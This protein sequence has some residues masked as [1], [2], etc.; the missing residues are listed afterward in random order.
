MRRPR[1]ILYVDGFNLYRRCLSSHPALK[2]LDLWTLGGL[3]M[4][5][6]DLIHVHYFTAR[7]RPGI[8]FDPHTPV[9]QQMYLRALETLGPDRLT[10]HFGKFRNDR[11]DMP[12]HPV[13][14]D[15]ATGKWATTPVKKLEEKGSDVNLASRMVADSLLGRADIVVMLSNDS[16]LAGPMR[17]LKQELGRSTGIIFPMD[18][19]RGSKELVATTP[20]FITHVGVDALRASQF[21]RRLEDATGEFHRPPPWELPPWEAPPGTDRGPQFPGAL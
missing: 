4:P 5:E 14:L 10:V 11:R 9:R 8:Q 20:D 16:D 17:M 19:S 2:W 13:R 12:I 6:Y 15:S 21:P 3:L 7:L 1:A 18:S